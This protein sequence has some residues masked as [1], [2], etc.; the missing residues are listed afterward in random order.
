MSG[1]LPLQQLAGNEAQ[2]LLR[3]AVAWLPA[4]VAAGA[5]LA[6]LTRLGW[7]GRTLV[8]ATVSWPVL[9]ASGAISDAIAL[10]ERVDQHLGP[11]LRSAGTWVAVGL[12]VIGSLLTARAGA[13]RGRARAATWR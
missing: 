12:M 7:V 11:Q 5:A 4:G 1:A 9:F 3:V 6:M 8:V 2:P 10:N 13:A